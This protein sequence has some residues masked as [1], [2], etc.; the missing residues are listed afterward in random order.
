VAGNI[1]PQT[2]TL[3]FSMAH[4]GLTWISFPFISLFLWRLLHQRSIGISWSSFLITLLIGL[5][6]DHYPNVEFGAVAYLH[7]RPW[8]RPGFPLALC[9]EP[10]IRTRLRIE[11]RLA[12]VLP[13]P[14]IGMTI[15]VLIPSI[16]TEFGAPISQAADRQLCQDKS[17]SQG[18]RCDL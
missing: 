10:C 18:Y 5:A 7:P 12:S 3:S 9:R 17:V 16:E 1:K 15:F 14:R 6:K 2:L 4:S 13:R 11:A 8:R